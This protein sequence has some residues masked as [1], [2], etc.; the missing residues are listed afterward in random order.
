LW[1][2][3]QALTLEQALQVA[4]TNPAPASKVAN[5]AP[6]L[7]P[8]TGHRAVSDSPATKAL[9]AGLSARQAEVLR[10]V[11]AGQS[12]RA[13]AEAL[14]LSEKT[15]INHLTAIFQKTGC[16]NRAAAVAFAIRQ[17]LA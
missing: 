16:D 10:C 17:G 14:N 5:Q 8:G 13:I 3:G 4:L 15:V 7:T 2:R 11:V 9:P 1:V 12:N 6:M